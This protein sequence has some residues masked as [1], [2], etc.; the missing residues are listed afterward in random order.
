MTMR[1][2]RC[3][4][5]NLADADFC[6]ECGAGLGLQCGICQA[7]NPAASKFCRKCGV[8]LGGAGAAAAREPRAPDPSSNAPAH[9]AEQFRDAQ[10]EQLRANTGER[11]F[12]T[13]LFADIRGSMSLL[14]QLDPEQARLIIDPALRLMMN[15]VFRYEGYVAQTLGDGIFALFGA[16]IARED[17]AR[18]ALYAALSMQEQ[19]R[20]YGARLLRDQGVPAL[21]IRVGVNSGE[22]VVR[23]IATDAHRA[24]YV[25]VGNS[26]GLAARVE[27]IAAPGTIL[28]TGSTYQL[29]EGYFEFRPLGEVPIKGVSARVKLYEVTGAG[30]L[31]T[32]LEVSASHGLARFVGRA[33]E[34][35]Q[36]NA[37]LDSA[38]TGHGRIA[39]VVGDAGVGK[40]RLCHE[41]KAMAARDCL[42]LECTLQSYGR[43]TAYQPLID[44][45]KTYFQVGAADGDRG[46]VEKVTGRV[47]ALDRRLDDTLPFLLSLLGAPG[48][49]APLQMMDQ[50]VR[51]QRTFDALQRLIL[52]LAVDQPVLM[53]MEDLHW[54]DDETRRFLASLAP[55]LHD[56]RILLLVNYRPEQAPLWD[57]ST[58]YSELRLEALAEQDASAL[59]R[60]LL[61]D[62]PALDELKRMVVDK[63]QGNPFFMEEYVRSLFDQGALVRGATI[64]LQRPIAAIQMPATVQGV[65]AARIDGLHPDDKAFLQLL[66]VLGAAA[67]LRLIEHLAQEPYDQLQNRLERLLSAEF[68]YVR[69]D[70]P[71]VEYV[72]KHA[73][74]RETAYGGLIAESRRA[75]HRLAAEAM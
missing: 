66:A 59:L 35:R 48:A 15:A 17:H 26:T 28:V 31:R 36:L 5:D 51:R 56:A 33:A 45:L 47:L 40:S 18:R 46:I 14:D 13:A 50:Q 54:L 19:M 11:K 72:F 24:D 42:V 57:E 10:A 16:P 71:D 49:D 37:L 67:P 73:L 69:A 4:F 9:L 29:T 65:L 61:G 6:Q 75:L 41:F 55:V 44:L 64:T 22:V 60:A 27:G 3:Q 74:T 12:I 1:C 2:P 58:G 32:R 52:R 34:L 63:T 62:D 68:L 7:V 21:Q 39:C 38:R 25:P 20:N 8:H 23:S 30:P 53:M 70:Y 43:G